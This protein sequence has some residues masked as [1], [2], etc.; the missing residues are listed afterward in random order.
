VIITVRRR[1]RKPKVEIVGKEPIPPGLVTRTNREVMN[2]LS[3]FN[4]KR[5]K[6]RR[7]ARDR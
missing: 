2:V 6:E 4:A 3:K 7:A 1:G 5:I